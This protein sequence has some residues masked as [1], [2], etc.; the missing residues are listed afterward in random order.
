MQSFNHL[1]DFNLTN[2][3]SPDLIKIR[4]LLCYRAEVISFLFIIFFLSQSVCIYII[5]HLAALFVRQRSGSYIQKKKGVYTLDS[6]IFN[7]FGRNTCGKDSETCDGTF[8]VRASKFVFFKKV[9]FPSIRFMSLT[10]PFSV[11][12]LHCATHTYTLGGDL[13]QRSLFARFTRCKSLYRHCSACIFISHI[14][15][16]DSPLCL[17]M[18]D[19]QCNI[20]FDQ[21]PKLVGFDWLSPVWPNSTSR[22]SCAQL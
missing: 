2:N 11:A 21:L 17:G 4:F 3:L 20:D 9:A 18:F 15:L 16:F 6:H 22:E 19:H 10:V 1:F 14:V 12:V 13:L 7:S 5:R 8:Y